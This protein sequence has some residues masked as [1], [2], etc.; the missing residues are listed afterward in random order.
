M[1]R[2]RPT[3]PRLLILAAVLAMVGSSGL[4]EKNSTEPQVHAASIGHGITL[5]YVEEGT[6]VAVIFVHGS[7]S[8]GGYWA[9]QIGRFAKQYRA[10]AYSRRYNY[11]NANPARHGYSAVVDSDDLAAFIHTLHLGKV[12]VIGHSYGALTGLFLAARHPEMVRA[13]VLAEPPAVSLLAEVHG[14]E[15]ER[16]K[17]M[18]DDIRHRLVTPM[19][20]AY[21]KGDREEGIRVF[22]AYVFNDPHAWDK[23]SQSSRDHTLQD[24]HEWDVMMTTGTLFPAITRQAVQRISAPALILMGANSYPFLGVI[25]RELARLLP[26]SQTIVFPDAGHQ[27]WLQDPEACHRDVEKFLADF[28]IR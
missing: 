26:R 6:G 10:I 19:Q 22:M 15:R 20:Q 9:D 24:A 3:N 8:D 1:P 27:M 13:L 4:A 16:G 17:E 11:P 12:V 21:Q 7:L 28:G 5:H 2:I 18:L 14:D 25:G 23:M